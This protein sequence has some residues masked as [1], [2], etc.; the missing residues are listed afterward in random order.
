MFIIMKK[1][2]EI[3]RSGKK[4]FSLELFPP[5]TSEGYT[6]LLATI[7]LLA[8]LKPDFISCTYGAG[9]GNR[10]KTLDIVEHIQNVHRIPGLA[11]LTCVSNTRDQIR[12]I[13]DD[14]RRR[15]ITN[16]LALRGDP[17]ADDPSWQPTDA[18]FRYAYE[19]CA[20]IKKIYGEDLC[21]GV[22]GFPEGHILCPD[23]ELDARYLKMKLDNGAAFVLTQLF[24]DNNDYF[25]YRDR[26]KKLGVQAPVIPGILPITDYQGVVNFSKKCG[27]RIPPK[28]HERFAPL[29][30]D[31]EATIKEGVRF[32]VDQCVEL[33]ANGAPGIHFYPLNKISPLDIILP[34]IKERLCV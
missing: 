8:G 20:F 18:H 12:S 29:S 30:G 17:P 4:V 19:L 5:K 1:I 7:G 11:H 13:L 22:A 27:T 6:K 25:T 10:D 14:I 33:L 2:S 21:L 3:L 31:K 24:F 32:C 26:L 16:I 9:G 23:K 15:G 34:R 28:I